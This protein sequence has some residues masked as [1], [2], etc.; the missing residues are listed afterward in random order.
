MK[1]IV[2]DGALQSNLLQA[3]QKNKTIQGQLNERHREYYVQLMKDMQEHNLKAKLNKEL[4]YAWRKENYVRQLKKNLRE[5]DR[6]RFGARDAYYEYQAR[7]LECVLTGQQ[8]LAIP[9]KEEERRLKVNSKFQQFLKEHPPGKT[10][11]TRQFQ[12]TN[13]TSKEEFDARGVEETWKHIHA[14][15]AVGLKRKKRNVLPAIQ[16]AATIGEIVRNKTAISTSTNEAVEVEDE[17][18]HLPVLPVAA[19]RSIIADEVEPIQITSEALEKET[20][21]DLVSMRSVRRPLKNPIDLNITFESRKRI[22]QINKRVS[23]YRICTRKC[24]LQRSTRFDREETIDPID[25]EDNLLVEMSE[26]T[27]RRYEDRHQAD[28]NF[29]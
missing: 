27:R 26:T 22:Y 8:G 4:L 29:I 28:K 15:S 18:K 9:P 23:E 5:Y 11:P 24:N 17:T 7:N 21:A 12:S 6:K 10:S 3:F 16:R 19:V 20:R 14:Q 2:D 25:D 13:A 1:H